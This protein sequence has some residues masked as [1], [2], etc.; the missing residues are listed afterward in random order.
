MSKR[1][2]VKQMTFK[3]ALLSMLERAWMNGAD[4]KS[5]VY[6]DMAN[7]DTYIK[8]LIELTPSSVLD[9]SEMDVMDMAEPP[10]DKMLM[11]ACKEAG[12][13]KKV[14]HHYTVQ[15]FDRLE[16]DRRDMLAELH[17]FVG[18]IRARAVEEGTGTAW[19]KSYGAIE[20][21]DLV[22]AYASPHMEDITRMRETV[23]DMAGAQDDCFDQLT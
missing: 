17:R 7:L 16:Q 18:E 1:N 9:A 13:A 8:Q 3:K 12:T 14:I 6:Q 15:S 2:A 20:A 19:G 4:P 10:A 21:L 22:E 5:P 11:D 23:R